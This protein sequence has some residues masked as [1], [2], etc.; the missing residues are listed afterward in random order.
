MYAATPLPDPIAPV[1]E[2]LRSQEMPP[3]EIRLVATSGDP[4]LVRRH[5]ELHRERLEESFDR[6]RVELSAL[7][8]LLLERAAGRRS[9]E[10]RP[11]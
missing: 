5:L 2:T 1:V 4:E 7:Q 11:R 10:V 8:A 9:A 3:Q 6:Q